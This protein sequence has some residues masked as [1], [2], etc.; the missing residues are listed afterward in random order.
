MAKGNISQPV[1][2][3]NVDKPKS[4]SN[5][6]G[7]A[8]PPM[9]SYARLIRDKNEFRGAGTNHGSDFN[10]FDTPT[11]K[12]FKILFYFHGRSEME[13]SERMST[14][15]LVP[16]WDY[17]L[18]DST[19]WQSTSAWAYLKMND[20]NERA[21]KL[22]QFISLLSNINS[23][24]PWYF[25]SISGLDSALERK[26]ATDGKLDLSEVKRL[27]IKCL[28]DAM[29]DR[30][31]TL[32]SL[33]RDVVWSWS[34]KKEILPVNLRKFD[35][36]VYVIEAPTWFIHKGSD[37]IDGKSEFKPSY[38]MFE[39]HNCEFDYNSVK[40]GYSEIS[41]QTGVQPTYT[42]DIMY[43]D[44]YEIS[45]NSILM[46]TIGDV[47]ATDTAYTCM[48]GG[49]TMASIT[50]KEQEDSLPQLQELQLRMTRT[51]EKADEVEDEPVKKSPVK[52]AVSQLVGAIKGDVKTL[53]K[54]IVLGN[55]YTVSLTQAASELKSLSQGNVIAAAQT[56]KQ[57]IKTA[58]ERAAMRNKKPASGNIYGSVEELVKGKP[59]GDIYPDEV[60]RKEHQMRDIYPDEVTRKEHVS[61]DIYPEPP[62]PQK[63]KLGNLYKGSIANN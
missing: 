12:F 10:I 55:I 33:Y 9:M 28:P 5:K 53:L 31:G 25:S 41:N 8:V 14:G 32:L 52:N 1:N 29:D 56:A 11:L 49:D 37:I 63:R 39:F 22:Q 58:Q 13:T 44:C 45:Y 48:R 18:D 17:N 43:D 19:Y 6:M 47:I 36:A 35:M 23:E 21:E 40:S 3:T 51:F 27:Q 57:Y 2:P 16:A 4:N 30:I 54:R 50:S 59:T 7:N 46:R 61:R 34:M 62:Q 15:L 60:T 38:K 26:V 20:E 24:S 42:I